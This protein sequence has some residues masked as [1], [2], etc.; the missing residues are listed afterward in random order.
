MRSEL[1]Y[2]LG[3]VL[4][5]CWFGCTTTTEGGEQDFTGPASLTIVSIVPAGTPGST[6]AQ[7]RIVARDESGTPLVGLAVVVGLSDPNATATPA[8][9]ITDAQG[10]LL[11]SITSS[12]A[13]TV[14]LA[15]SAGDQTRITRVG[16]MPPCQAVAF[17]RQQV[18]AAASSGQQSLALGDINGDGALDLAVQSD[19]GFV[20]SLVNESDGGFIARGPFAGGSTLHMLA[21]TLV[22]LNGDH[23]VDALAATGAYPTALAMFKNI[24]HGLFNTAVAVVA[25]INGRPALGDLDGDGYSDIAGTS[26]ASAAM[27][28]LNNDGNAHFISNDYALQPGA[29][30]GDVALADFDGDGRLDVIAGNAAGAL[31]VFYNRTPLRM[32]PGVAVTLGAG[33]G[34]LATGDVNNDGHVD[35]VAMSSMGAYLDVALNQGDGTLLPQSTMAVTQ[36]VGRVWLTDVDGDKNLDVIA[37]VAATGTVLIYT[38]G[39]DGTFAS[40]TSIDV[41]LLN[42]RDLV[43][44]DFN[45]DGRPDIAVAAKGAVL[46]LMNV[47]K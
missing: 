10:A 47:C 32:L 25:P 13:S 27:V 23:A 26:A 35:V 24:G 3:A 6:A 36:G 40:A 14:D 18:V 19:T 8:S 12:V 17:A 41:G 37:S 44:A 39:G 20:I 5:A 7:A 9:G 31:S 21:P 42:P 29:Q 46:V 1:R 11:V 30:A 45:D 4:L 15:A 43:V 22:D 28:T 38:G 16:F 33:A 34:L 2:G